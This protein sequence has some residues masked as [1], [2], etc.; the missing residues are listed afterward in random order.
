MNYLFISLYYGHQLSGY[1]NCIVI[2][3][4]NNDCQ[5]LKIYNDFFYLINEREFRTN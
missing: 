4:K 3:E 1:K 5:R 2:I